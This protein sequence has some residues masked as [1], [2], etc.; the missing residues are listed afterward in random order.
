MAK[1]PANVP[2]QD[3]DDKIMI[4]RSEYREL[5][6]AQVLLKAVKDAGYLEGHSGNIIMTI[7]N[8]EHNYHLM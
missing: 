7:A 4:S 6:K 5:Q 8:Q 1:L 2:I 3:D